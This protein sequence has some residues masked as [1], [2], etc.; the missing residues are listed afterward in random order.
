M[1][2]VGGI[3]THIFLRL[4]DY[5]PNSLDEIARSMDILRT[6]SCIVDKFRTDVPKRSYVINSNANRSSFKPAEKMKEVESESIAEFK[7]YNDDKD[8]AASENNDYQ[9][10]LKT[11]RSTV[12]TNLSETKIKSMVH[13]LKNSSF[14]DSNG[15]L[16]MFLNNKVN[17][18][19]ILK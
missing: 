3:K 17:I 11:G 5:N 7:K 14:L 16:I 6:K 19:V 15:D 18:C 13:M 2:N 12:K 8:S 10:S 4:I 9:A 1:N